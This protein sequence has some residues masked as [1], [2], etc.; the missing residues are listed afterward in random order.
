MSRVLVALFVLVA[1]ATAH[2]QSA[3]SLAMV[4]ANRVSTALYYQPDQCPIDYVGDVFAEQ[5]CLRYSGGID[6][7]TSE[8]NLV[9]LAFNDVRWL[10]PWENLGVDYGALYAR[11]MLLVPDDR[12]AVVALQY[13]GDY[14]SFLYVLKPR[15]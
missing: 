2:A 1:L 6:A 8:I 3:E 11:N 4:L 14:H 10:S 7:L 13:A 12:F 5:A 9:M 15:P